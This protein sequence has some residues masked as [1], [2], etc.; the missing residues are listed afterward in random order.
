MVAGLRW[1]AKYSG[2]AGKSPQVLLGSINYHRLCVL[3]EEDDLQMAVKV[4]ASASLSLFRWRLGV[5]CECVY[6]YMKVYA[7]SECAQQHTDK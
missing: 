4:P 6:V 7:R 1:R 3:C 5:M 2:V